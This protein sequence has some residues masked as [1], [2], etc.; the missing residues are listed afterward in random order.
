MLVDKVVEL[1]ARPLRDFPE[2]GQLADPAELIAMVC[3]S[4]PT[5]EPPSASAVAVSG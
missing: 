5:P 4:T 1:D 2:L 3:F